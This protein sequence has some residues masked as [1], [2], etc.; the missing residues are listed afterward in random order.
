MPWG[1][2]HGAV[3]RQLSTQLTAVFQGRK[4]KVLPHAAK[5]VLAA[6][7]VCVPESAVGTVLAS[8]PARPHLWL[9]TCHAAA[10]A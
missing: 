3:G 1:I 6:G 8:W 4:R 5:G 9:C 2:D 7:G 10:V